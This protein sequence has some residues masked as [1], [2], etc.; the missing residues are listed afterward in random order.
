MFVL[1]LEGERA[2]SR[3]RRIARGLLSRRGELIPFRDAQQEA[4]KGIFQQQHSHC[5]DAKM[6]HGWRATLLSNF[7]QIAGISSGVMFASVTGGAAALIPETWG[8]GGE[9]LFLQKKCCSIWE[10][11]AEGDVQRNIY[12]FV[13]NLFLGLYLI[14]KRHR[15]LGSGSDRT[16]VGYSS[17]PQTWQGCCRQAE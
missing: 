9:R 12:S 6:Q 11:W 8:A 13:S 3:Q 10:V 5:W 7:S 14:I 2:G 16:S 15:A 1:G 4:W 17:G